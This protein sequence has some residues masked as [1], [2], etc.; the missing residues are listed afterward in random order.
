MNH[1]ITGTTM[2]V[3]EFA[4]DHN[5]AIISEAGELSWMSAS[6]QMTTH[7]QMGGGGGFFGA[8]RRV[9]GGG[10]LFMT[11]YRALGAP[12]EV[13]FATRVPG[14]IVPLPV[15]NGY[16]YLIHRHGFL[17]ATAGVELGLGFQQSLGA[18]IFGGDGFLL[19][20]ISGQGTAWLEL[21]G[22]VIT[23]DLAAGELLRV[24][25]GHVGGFQTSV[26]FQIQRI[27]G[28]KNMIFGGDGIFLAALTGP[29]RVWLQTL[30][31]SRLAQQLQEYM[32]GRRSEQAVE[33]G[34]VGGIVGSILKGM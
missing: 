29:G 20:K 30:P 14:H 9:A 32:P 21:S 34:V 15:G 25:P 17:C 10:S 3:L 16:E 13:A 1:R 11:E 4:L 31:I 6:I 2:P 12:G 7:T 22:E 33:G 26:S 23:K 19:Q 27:P 28:I 5:D 8:I 18:G 24:H